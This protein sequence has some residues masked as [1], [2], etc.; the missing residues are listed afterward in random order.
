MSLREVQFKQAV[1]RALQNVK[2]VLDTTRNPVY[3]SNGPHEYADKYALVD[4]ATQAAGTSILTALASGIPNIIPALDTLK[5]SAE[6]SKKTVTLRFTSKEECKFQNTTTRKVESPTSVVKES[7]S[8]V[9]GTS[10]STTKVVT[11]VTEHHWE[12]NMGYTISAFLGNDSENATLLSTGKGKQQF[13]TVGTEGQDPRAPLPES[14]I[15]GPYDADITW[16]LSHFDGGRVKFTVD[17]QHDDCHTPRRNKDVDEA[18]NAL[19]VLRGFS[20]RVTRYIVNSCQQADGRAGDSKV[21]MNVN[22]D[23]VFSPVLVMFALEKQPDDAKCPTMSEGDF[24]AFIKALEE[25]L[26]SK[27]Q[28]LS[29]VLLPDSSEEVGTMADGLFLLSLL[30]VSSTVNEYYSAVDAIEA[31]MRQQ[32]IAAI[33]KEIGPSDFAEYMTFHNRNLFLEKYMP[34]AFC[35]S[36]QRP[37]M[38]PEGTFSIEKDA[39][40]DKSAEPLHTTSVCRKAEAPMKFPLNAAADVYFLGDRY[41]HACIMTQFSGQRGMQVKLAARARQFSSFILMLGKI[42]GPDTFDPSEAII[43]QNK[44]DLLI[45]LIFETVPTPKEFRDAIESLSPEQQRFAKAFRSMQ[46]AST[47][48]AVCIVQIKPQ[49]ERVLNLP[50]GSLTKEIKLTQELMDMFV[51][52]QIPSDLMTYDGEADLPV[53]E[54]VEKV[55]GFVA[56]LQEMI[57]EAKSSELSGVTQEAVKDLFDG[58]TGDTYNAMPMSNS[59]GGGLGGAMM[60]RG[61]AIPQ[62]MPMAAMAESAMAPPMA[63]SAMAPPGAALRSKSRAAPKRAPVQQQQQQRK[64]EQTVAQPSKRPRADATIEG[65]TTDYTKLPTLLDQRFEAFDDDSALRPTIIKTEDQWSKKS[66]NGLLSKPKTNSLNRDDQR[67]EKSKAFDLLDALTRSGVLALEHASLHVILAATHCFDKTLIDSVIQGNIN[68]IEK[69][70]RSSLIVASAIH[71]TKPA[72]MVQASQLDRVSGFSPKLFL[73]DDN[74]MDESES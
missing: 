2:K 34:R 19:S 55:K 45:P 58:M 53:A 20:D 24:D 3:P 74:K 71:G 12:L 33:G 28:Q 16:L 10:K 50:S 17:R 7:T 40:G 56:N 21:R 63:R 64:P 31:I 54:K 30:V 70:E 15:I 18:M 60:K 59:F 73:E 23:N 62:A 37:Q 72:D 39:Q 27:K 44:D 1:E 57:Q 68:P 49:L 51:K 48:F 46:L 38:F 22:K 9:F 42:S 41:V 8:T 69:V 65:G 61:A 26:V 67:E 32:L 14:N 29:A 6:S 36:V 4:L 43:V 52:Y 35:Y 66:Q 5:K 13:K 11:K 25:S 47:L